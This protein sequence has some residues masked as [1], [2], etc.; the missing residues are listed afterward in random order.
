MAKTSNPIRH[1]LISDIGV[2]ED[3]GYLE[4]EVDEGGGGNGEQRN[5]ASDEGVAQNTDGIWTT[6]SCKTAKGYKIDAKQ[7]DNSDDVQ[8]ECDL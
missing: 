2:A 5:Q 8:G 7:D 3:M 4:L 1:F 6:F